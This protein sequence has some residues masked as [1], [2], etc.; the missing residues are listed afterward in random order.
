MR[1]LKA[2]ECLDLNGRMADDGQKRLVTPNV[3]FQRCDIEIA[4]DHGR[5]AQLF[6]PA[7]HP[8]DEIQFLTEF[9]IDRS[10]RNIA[11]GGH[12]DIFQPYPIW[13]PD[14]DMTGFA[15]ILP[16]V[17]FCVA[18]LH[19]TEDRNAMVHPLPLEL[20]V[21]VPVTGEKLGREDII[22][23]LGFLQAKNVRPLLV[24]EPLHDRQPRT[25]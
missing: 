4:D 5:L 23:R 25:H 14:A 22:G 12:I 24:K 7:D 6:R 17:A 15:V 19:P 21:D 20:L 10:V 18:H 3:A 1:L 13:K 11:A 16:I 8:P 9:G 2:S